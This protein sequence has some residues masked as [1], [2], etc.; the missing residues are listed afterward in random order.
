MLAAIALFLIS[1]QFYAPDHTHSPLEFV[2][3]FIGG[4]SLFVTAIAIWFEA[5][6]ITAR[7]FQVDQYVNAV[8]A[9][10]SIYDEFWTEDDIAEVRCWLVSEVEYN[11]NLR[12]IL[13]DR[14]KSEINRLKHEH[15]HKLDKLD[16]FLAVLVRIRSFNT[17]LEFSLINDEQKKI[18]E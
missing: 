8:N 7:N 5:N 2:G 3:S 17:S 11:E 9:F 4:V 14:C 6:T 18:V 10:R 15:N 12:G 16:R 13:A 1:Y